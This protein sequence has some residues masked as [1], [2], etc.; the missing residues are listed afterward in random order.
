MRAKDR[1]RKR[2]QREKLKQ[3]IQSGN[4]KLEDTLRTKNTEYVRKYRQNKKL[5]QKDQKTAANKEKVLPKSYINKEKK[6]IAKLRT[7]KWRMKIKLANMTDEISSD[8]TGS[9]SDVNSPCASKGTELSRWTIYRWTKQVKESLPKTPEKRISIIEK[10]SDSPI[11]SS[12]LK[13]KGKIVTGLAKKKLEM[14]E[15][16]VN[17]LAKNLNETCG[18]QNKSRKVA[19][20]A[21]LK[22][23]VSAIGKK[24]NLGLKTLNLS[25]KQVKKVQKDNSDW[26]KPNPRKKRKDMITDEIKERVKKF[27]LQSEISREVPNK[28]DVVCL[29]SGSDKQYV[30]KHIMIMTSI[31]AYHMYRQKYQQDKIGLSKFKDLK[32]KQVRRISETN[33]KSCLC[34]VCCNIALKSEA[35]ASFL[36]NNREKLTVSMDTDKVTLSN[37]TLCEI[38]PD[39]NHNPKCLRRECTACGPSIL[40]RYL[41]P[42]AKESCEKGLKINWHKWD[43]ISVEREDGSCKK[44]KSCV[45]KL[46]TFAEFTED[47]IKDITPYPDHKFRA[48][49]QQRQMQ[50]CL[51]NLSKNELMMIMDFS[52][53]Y[54]CTFQ[55]EIQSA[56]FDQNLVTIHPIMCYYRKDLKGE[57][58][59]YKHSIIGISTDLKHD[60][61]L[62]KQFEEKAF[63]RVR[64]FTDI[65][66]V[67]EWTDGC[68][69]QY[70]SKVA[71]AYLSQ[72]THSVSRD[73][74]ETSHGKNVCDGLGAIV[75]NSCHRAMLTGKVIGTANS[76]FNHCQTVLAHGVKVDEKE[77]VVKVRQFVFVDKDEVDR[78]NIPQAETLV[79]TRKVHSVRNTNV[80][81]TIKSRNLSCYCKGCISGR[82]CENHTYVS[83]WA[84]SSLKCILYFQ[85]ISSYKQTFTKENITQER[86][87]SKNTAISSLR[88]K[89]ATWRHKQKHQSDEIRT[90]DTKPI[91]K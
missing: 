11:T 28:K 68:A 24:Y 9:S 63:D 42:L 13:A 43:T 21:L 39:D 17:E 4:R 40:R 5:K 75:K 15:T 76:V 52:E 53:N 46:T 12:R 54:K 56:Y 47:L 84:V 10:I 66:I 65:N 33:K 85:S 36:K 23:A 27:Y 19:N 50:E 69:A 20:H 62:V 48:Q 87:K 30:Q 16:V 3:A 57:E 31:D 89:Y 73:F 55:N 18:K 81:M 22:T 32:P 88:K 35:L 72:T 29:K 80:Q 37:K 67:K 8:A 26:W 7:Q 14:A 58:Y 86:P 59:L 82:D 77:K 51:K 70:K 61:T 34:Q 83:D 90:N 49:W 71:F 45:P 38:G 2:E 74:F 25:R 1:E 91:N 79:G 78:K 60:S 64:E 44:I 41:E 6:E